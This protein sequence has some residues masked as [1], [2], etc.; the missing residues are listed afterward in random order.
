MLIV[1]DPTFTCLEGVHNFIFLYI[2][3]NIASEHFF[4]LV[5]T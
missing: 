2:P 5:L 3:N 1:E 4:Q